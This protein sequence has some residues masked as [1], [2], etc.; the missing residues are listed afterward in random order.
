MHTYNSTSPPKLIITSPLT[1]LSDSFVLNHNLPLLRI[2]RRLRFLR[3]DHISRALLDM[4]IIR[5]LMVDQY[6]AD[7]IAVGFCEFGAAKTI[8]H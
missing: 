3:S 8:I 1:S 5:L 4:R 2:L 6:T 7:F